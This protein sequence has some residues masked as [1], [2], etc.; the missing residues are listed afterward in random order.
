MKASYMVLVKHDRNVVGSNTIRPANA[1]GFLIYNGTQ[2]K[3]LCDC[4]VSHLRQGM[5]YFFA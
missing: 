3:A 1:A 2:G 4:R 5:E